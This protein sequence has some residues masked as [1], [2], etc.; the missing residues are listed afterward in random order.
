M[1]KKLIFWLILFS[2]GSFG[3]FRSLQIIRK[4]LTT[5]MAP[6]VSPK[7]IKP[8]SSEISIDQTQSGYHQ[9]TNVFDS[10]LNSR[11]SNDGLSLVLFTASWCGPC[12]NMATSLLKCSQSASQAANFYQIDTDYNPESA[13]EYH[14]R[15]IP[16]VLIFKDG[17][18]VAEIVGN[19]P[20]QVV[21]AQILKHS[22]LNEKI[23]DFQ[24]LDSSFQ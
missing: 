14:V 4:K 2:S 16:C 12:K 9:L 15:S 5:N 21:E 8:N 3:L 17:K 18:V 22:S 7:T 19:V 11:I 24:E 13:S 20:I 6:V 23:E 10:N 1:T